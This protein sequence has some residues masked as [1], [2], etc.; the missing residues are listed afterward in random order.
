LLANV[1]AVRERAAASGAGYRAAA[2]AIA[3]DRVVRALRLRGIYA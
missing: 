3:I 1:G 2:Y